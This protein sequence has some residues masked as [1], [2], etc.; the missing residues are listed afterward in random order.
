M[1]MVCACLNLL[2]RLKR[3]DTNLIFNVLALNVG[4]AIAMSLS[5]VENVHLLMFRLCN[6]HVYKLMPQLGSHIA[7]TLF[8]RIFLLSMIIYLWIL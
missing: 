1:T 7:R 5:N 8:V 3:I 4:V 6:L 2:V